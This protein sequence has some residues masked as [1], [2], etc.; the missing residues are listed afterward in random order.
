MRLFILLLLFLLPSLAHAQ[1]PVVSANGFTCTQNQ[2]LVN[3]Y[4]QFPQSYGVFSA[5]GMYGVQMTYE[6]HSFP[7]LRYLFDS[8]SGCLMEI[9]LN[10]QGEAMQA[11]VKT[12]SGKVQTFV[13]PV[14]QVQANGFCRM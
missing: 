2:S 9:A 13:L 6:T 8:R 10:S 4:G 3:C 12:A 5:S 14:Q 7:K 1:L 11:L